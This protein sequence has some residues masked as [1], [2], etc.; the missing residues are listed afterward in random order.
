MTVVRR[1]AWTLASPDVWHPVIRAYALA[2]RV[3]QQRPANDPTSWRYQAAV[4]ATAQAPDQ[5]RNQCQHNTWFFLPWHRTYLAWFERIVRDIVAT[6][7]GVDQAT[8][9]G[10]AL[11]YWDYGRSSATRALPPA[12]RAMTLPDGSPN[13]LRVPGRNPG[14]N[15]G[16]RLPA[17][18]A[19]ATLALRQVPFSA[20]PA[21]GITAGFGGSATGANHFSES[22][23]AAPGAVELTPHGDVHTQVGGP[24]GLMSAFDTAPLDPV[25][26]LHH[27]NIDRLWEVWRTQ[28]QRRNPTSGAWLTTVFHFHDEQGD[29][30]KGVAD[31]VLNTVTDLDYRYADLSL[32]AGPLEATAMT[33]TPPDHPAE[34]VGATDGTVELTGQRATVDFPLAAPSGP[35]SGDAGGIPTRVYV[36]VEDV[37]APA[38]PGIS[39]AVY[40]NVPDDDD[41]PT[42]DAHYIGNVSFFGIELTADLDRDHPGGL[43]MAFDVT[44]L[45]TDLRERGLWDDRVRVTFAPLGLDAPLPDDSEEPGPDDSA[46]VPAETPTVQIGRV[47]VFYQ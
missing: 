43:R 39:Y 16:G 7:P 25:F 27:A 36:N 22:P 11:P 29:P 32:P 26:W 20:R 30:V 18:A 5:F 34:L 46:H 23:L 10:W 47:S 38:N 15:T 44:D 35:L 45:Y 2:V 19:S 8:K 3:M 40:V 42:N 9:D 37:R 14:L 28:P 24:G 21:P 41:D 17:S 1:D 31:D 4:H 33:P 12:F 13:P 6:L